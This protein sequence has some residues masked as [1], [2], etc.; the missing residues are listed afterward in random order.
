MQNYY[1]IFSMHL[2]EGVQSPCRSR[3]RKR[4]VPCPPAMTVPP[5]PPADTGEA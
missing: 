1:T 3:Q 2:P 4:C 5:P